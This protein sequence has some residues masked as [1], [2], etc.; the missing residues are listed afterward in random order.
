MTLKDVELMQYRENR[1]E[2]FENGAIQSGKSKQKRYWT[3]SSPDIRHLAD[4]GFY[5]TPTKLNHDQIT[6]ISCKKKET[7][8]GGVENIADHHLANN[9]NCPYSLLISSQI[10]YLTD[11]QKDYWENHAIEALREPLSKQAVAIRRKTFGSYWKF[12]KDRKNAKA[13]SL[14]LAKSGFYYCPLVLGN[15]RVQCVYC[16]CSLDTWSPDDDPV[17][18]HRANAALGCY[19]LR[20]YDEHKASSSRSSS[21]SR[22]RSTSRN[23]SVSFDSSQDV[24][25]SK[26]M[27]DL[28]KAVK[29][30]SETSTNEQDTAS[31]FTDQ[32]DSKVEVVATQEVEKVTP[33]IDNQEYSSG[34]TR[35]AANSSPVLESS[36]AQNERAD[37]VSKE[38]FSDFTSEPS[39]EENHPPDLDDHDYHETEQ[40]DYK[41][42]LHDSS[43]QTYP[44]RVTR[45]R[46]KA[47]S[48]TKGTDDTKSVSPDLPTNEDIPM[49][50]THAHEIEKSCTNINE[51]LSEDKALPNTINNRSDTLRSKD[52]SSGIQK[53]RVGSEVQILE[54]DIDL[55]D[56]WSNHESNGIKPIEN[57]N[58]SERVPVNEDKES[59]AVDKLHFTQDQDKERDS[60]T[61]MA[62]DIN[63]N[64]NNNND[65][66]YDDEENSNITND[67][68]TASSDQSTTKTNNDSDASYDDGDDD[69]GS[70][71]EGSASEMNESVPKIS[72]TGKKRTRG[73]KVDDAAPTNNSNMSS[74]SFDEKMLDQV[75]QSPR[76]SKK[77][78]L[79]KEGRSTSPPV[80]DSSNHNIGDYNEE[81]VTY[82]ESNINPLRREIELAPL[83]KPLKKN[84]EGRRD[85]TTKMESHKLKRKKLK[86]SKKASSSNN[87][88]DMQ[89]DDNDDLMFGVKDESL[90]LNIR[91]PLNQRDVN[92][93]QSEP[94]N[95]QK[96][97]ELSDIHEQINSNS[98]EKQVE[99]REP[100][101]V[102]EGKAEAEKLADVFLESA[103]TSIKKEVDSADY[104]K[105]KEAQPDASTSSKESNPTSI[106]SDEKNSD[107]IRTTLLS[108]RNELNEGRNSVNSKISKINPI[109]DFEEDAPI[110]NGNITNEIPEIERQ[111]SAAPTEDSKKAADKA[112]TSKSN[113]ESPM[114]SKKDLLDKIS[115]LR[116][117]D[118][119]DDLEDMDRIAL[120]SDNVE[121]R[122]RSSAGNNIQENREFVAGNSASPWDHQE[123]DVPRNSQDIASTKKVAP[124][125]KDVPAT[126]PVKT[127]S[128]PKTENS[129]LL[130]DLSASFQ[131]LVES[132]TPEKH[133]LLGR[134]L[135]SH[136]TEPVPSSNAKPSK[137]S[138]VPVPEVSQVSKTSPS[139]FSKSSSLSGLLENLKN[140]EAASEYLSKSVNS[141]YDLH[142]DYDGEL[143]NFISNMP[144]EE[145]NMTIHQWIRHNAAN[146]HKLA[147]QTCQEMID[148]YKEECQKAI[149]FL[150]QLPT[151]K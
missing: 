127:M 134:D 89:S 35:N 27:L 18:E 111:S 29:L 47:A 101:D 144:E 62:L 85:K 51:P 114:K 86:S 40:K 45:S 20:K 133:T 32:H 33:E 80:H 60:K 102:P 46:A 137:I 77:V 54:R 149:E 105:E 98:F 121:R 59:D 38:I 120:D 113:R 88:L 142:D 69:D 1:I 43:R 2:T 100:P 58:I 10:E 146:C 49:N 131:N 138:S 110:S 52:E 19:F 130:R 15:D 128:S 7:N 104:S 23:N 21:R 96:T 63:D 115:T 71:Y 6:C 78:K 73:L 34:N 3:H 30:K 83:V 65:N 57:N 42:D 129:P 119:V 4:C 36:S 112:K 79:N 116:Y 150:E 8:I 70:V 109:V 74:Y 72:L 14:A 68:N 151:T 141:P 9:P 123:K 125:E 147:S 135:Q 140:M 11:P 87:I 117:S 81:A 39:E 67:E 145:E 48:I 24:E 55:S 84:V 108:R 118:Y 37:S 148:A 132:S 95:I 50:F 64:N 31:L 139:I 75:I 97:E 107:T 41:Q 5:F 124:E 136:D 126:S 143:T 61:D 93:E 122:K 44:K 28:K 91:N 82:F 90:I 16:D 92:T 56:E 66:A 106:I 94:N 22:S 103:S 26:D 12:D 13:T 76:K 17:A 53:P 99:L 25:D